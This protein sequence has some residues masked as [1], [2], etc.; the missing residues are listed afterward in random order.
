[1]LS[2]AY[3]H[4]RVDRVRTTEFRENKN[5]KG[6]HNGSIIEAVLYGQILSRKTCEG[7]SSKNRRSGKDE[8]FVENFKLFFVTFGL[9]DPQELS[10]TMLYCN[11]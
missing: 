10:F 4:I 9:D 2:C 7:E 8:R 1:M 5:H 6:A 3:A 11:L